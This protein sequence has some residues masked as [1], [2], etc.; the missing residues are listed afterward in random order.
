M[1][2]SE[3]AGQGS[4]ARTCAPKDWSSTSSLLES[5][6]GS[7]A[8]SAAAGAAAGATSSLLVSSS[9]ASFAAS[10][11]QVAREPWVSRPPSLS[12]RA[13]RHLVLK[14]HIAGVGLVAAAAAR[15][16]G[17]GRLR[18][19]STAQG[20]SESGRPHAHA[21]HLSNGVAEEVSAAAAVQ[22]CGDCAVLSRRCA[23]LAGLCV[24]GAEQ[25]RVIAALEEELVG[26]QHTCAPHTSPHHTTPG[27]A[28]TFAAGSFAPA[29]SRSASS[30]LSSSSASASLAGVRA[31][32]AASSS[33]AASSALV[34]FG[35][36]LSLLLSSSAAVS[37]SSAEVASFF[38]GVPPISS[39]S[40]V[41][42]E[43]D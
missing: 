25:V 2:A 41:L 13:Q 11:A 33:G 31:G 6:R 3:C 29:P 26:L 4:S 16:R 34:L 32:A 19:H 22:Q 28:A 35:R 15:V 24:R 12:A 39:E 43:R 37:L 1:S 5:K 38:G 17:S 8:G 20:I 27:L 21:L 10:C 23:R 14:H 36:T 18:L 9:A 42:M 30:L 40:S 7:L